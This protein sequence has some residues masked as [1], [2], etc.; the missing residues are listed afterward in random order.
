MTYLKQWTE[1][2]FSDM[3]WHDAAIYSISFP[4]VDH[5]VSLDIDYI[6][7]WHWNSRTLGGWEVAPCTLK[8]D[9]VSHLKASLDW[10]MQGDTSIQDIIRA[11]SRLAPNNEILIWDYVIQLDVGEI[12]F[13]ATGFT[14]VE[15]RPPIFSTS[16]TLGRL[17]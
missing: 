5:T 11:N 2:D 6:L 10:Q 15:K 9:N 1:A 12:S 8:F 3:G 17:T 16:K 7:K 14:Q 13:T 4:Q